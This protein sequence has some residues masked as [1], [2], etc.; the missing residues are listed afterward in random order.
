M[1]EGRGYQYE[2]INSYSTQYLSVSEWFEQ[3]SLFST[4]SIDVLVQFYLCFNFYFPLFLC[5]VMYDN[6]VK[7]KESKS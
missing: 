4:L 6:E 3:T 7:T 2:K 1:R 5:V